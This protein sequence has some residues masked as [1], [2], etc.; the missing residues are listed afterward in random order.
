L[1]NNRK[2]WGRSSCWRACLACESPRTEPQNHMPNQHL[3]FIITVILALGEQVWRSGWDYSK[4]F[5]II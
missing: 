2:G 1:A 5:C 4:L 3:L